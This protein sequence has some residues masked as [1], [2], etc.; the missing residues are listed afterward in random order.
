MMTFEKHLTNVLCRAGLIESRLYIEKN[1][2]VGSNL[3]RLNFN[4]KVPSWV[5]DEEF[6]DKYSY[7]DSI[8]YVHNEGCVY[9]RRHNRY[10]SITKYTNNKYIIINKTYDLNNIIKPDFDFL[11]YFKNEYE[12]M[13]R[14]IR[15]EIE[16]TKIGEATAKWQAI[17]EGKKFIPTL[18]PYKNPHISLDG[19]LPF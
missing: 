19:D 2:P 15:S 14:E 10:V 6:L 9:F 13:F 8:K 3:I 18:I 5:N 17:T 1:V 4:L 16:L 12:K 7:I 11:G